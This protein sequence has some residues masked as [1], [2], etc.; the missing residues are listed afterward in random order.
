MSTKKF[1]GVNE[2]DSL[3]STYKWRIYLINGKEL[4]GYSKGKYVSEPADKT[5]LLERCATRLLKSGYYQKE[6][7]KYIQ[8]FFNRYLSGNDE[9]IL[10]MFPDGYSLGNNEDIVADH[11]LKDFLT[12]FYKQI[13][14]DTPAMKTIIHKIKHSAEEDL[15][16]WRKKR[17]NTVAELHTFVV[18]Q[19]DLRKEP[20][21]VMDFF[22]KY[23]EKWPEILNQPARG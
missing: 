9:W 13:T 17:F 2:W 8:F 6:R 11:R 16:D 22:R 18:K 7:T 14:G 3:N 21:M 23:L 20:A 12:L 19:I 10:T 15:F 1:P 4:V 5:V